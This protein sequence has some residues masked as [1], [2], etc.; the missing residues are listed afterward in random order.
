MWQQPMVAVS[1]QMVSGLN[2]TNFHPITVADAARK[3][4]KF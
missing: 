2:F 4:V 3:L 1:E